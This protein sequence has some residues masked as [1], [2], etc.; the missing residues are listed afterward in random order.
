MPED[1]VLHLQDE[2]ELKEGCIGEDTQSSP[3]TYQFRISSQRVPRG[4]R[5]AERLRASK[6]ARE[7]D[8][9]R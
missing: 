5:V 4:D 1:D 6:P 8:G 9:F 3:R 2:R 7:H